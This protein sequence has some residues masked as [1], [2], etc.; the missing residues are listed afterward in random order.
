MRVD[1]P[2]DSIRLSDPFILADRASSMYYMTGTGGMI[3]KSRDLKKW[4]GPFA[5]AKTDTLSW[6]GKNPMIWA[7]ELHAN[8]GKY[9][10]FA[11]FT[12]REVKIDTVK[13]NVIERRACHVLVSYSPGG[14]Y[15]PMKDPVYLPAS[16]PTLD[17]TFWMENRTC[18]IAMNGCKTGLKKLN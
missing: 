13:G 16:K 7:A 6:M 3:W 9:Y 18:F 10:Y 17:A 2:L 14:P 12:N 5:V 11:T 1:V 8:K 15:V 4:T